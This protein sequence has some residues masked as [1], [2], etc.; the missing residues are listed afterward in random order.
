MAGLGD[1]LYLVEVAY[2]ILNILLKFKFFDLLHLLHS[3]HLLQFDVRK[4]Q[5]PLLFNFRL[6]F[7]ILESEVSLR[8]FQLFVQVESYGLLRNLK[9]NVGSSAG[10]SH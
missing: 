2:A 3:L 5:L 4:E 1:I 8:V 9:Q 10:Y 6:P 7:C